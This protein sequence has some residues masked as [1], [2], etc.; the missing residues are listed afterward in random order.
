MADIRLLRAE[1]PAEA[2]VPQLLNVPKLLRD[3]A[4][5][6]DAGDHGIREAKEAFGDDIVL[7]IALVMRVTGQEPR[8]FGFG[9][10]P[11]SVTY[12]DLHAGAQELM[13]M[14]HPER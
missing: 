6:I 12:M 13:V 4:D 14:R 5:A 8:V 11:P 7:R 1:T 2:T 10:T 9:D 3:L